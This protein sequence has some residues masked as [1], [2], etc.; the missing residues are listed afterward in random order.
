M[1]KLIPVLLVLCTGLF[2]MSGCKKETPSGGNDGTTPCEKKDWY[3]DADGDGKGNPAVTV[4]QCD[5]PEGYVLDN[6]DLIDTEVMQTATPL[7]IKMTGETCPPC[8]SW[9]WGAFEDLYNAFVGKGLY[10]AN[11][12]DGFSNNHFRGQEI[13]ATNDAIDKIENMF[14]TSGGKPTFTAN[15]KD[16]NQQETDAI[17]E[18]NAFIATTPDASAVLTHSIDGDELTVNAQAKFFNDVTG[19]Y[20]MAAYL[21]EDKPVAYQAGHADGANTAHHHV[22]RGS[23]SDNAWGDEIVE[24]STTA[25]TMFEKTYTVTIPTT[26]DKAHLDYGIVIWKRTS[27]TYEFVNAYSTQN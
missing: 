14:F 27:N 20:Y 5:A 22:L 23:L 1:K 16:F 3:E 13:N 12:G 9:G 24:T 2:V 8:G 26:Y 4:N 19:K 25:G 11:Y 15:G 18:G 7:L 10:W 6:T 17:N 21:I